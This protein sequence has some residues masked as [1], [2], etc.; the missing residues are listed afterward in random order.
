MNKGQSGMEDTAATAN[1]QESKTLLRLTA[2]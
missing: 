2:T 1:T